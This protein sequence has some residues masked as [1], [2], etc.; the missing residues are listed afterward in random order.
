MTA[1]KYK[2]RQTN[3]RTMQ[4]WLDHKAPKWLADLVKNNLKGFSGKR[5]KR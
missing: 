5:K 3:K 4:Y 1:T 2:D